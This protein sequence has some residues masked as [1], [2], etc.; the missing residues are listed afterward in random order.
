MRLQHVGDRQ[1]GGIRPG[2]ISLIL[3]APQACTVC[4]NPRSPLQAKERRE[5]IAAR[6]ENFD[7]RVLLAFC[8]DRLQAANDVLDHRPLKRLNLVKGCRTPCWRIWQAG[9][10]VS[11]AYSNLERVSLV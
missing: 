10:S 6:L 7:Y 4:Q 8:E 5:M 1:L 2:Q 3:D 11:L 9:R